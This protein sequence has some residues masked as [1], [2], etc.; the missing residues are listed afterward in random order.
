MR[1]ERD[2]QIP[3]EDGYLNGRSSSAPTTNAINFPN[4]INDL[5]IT[6]LYERRRA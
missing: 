5:A 4:F 3:V 1:I 6:P 2:V